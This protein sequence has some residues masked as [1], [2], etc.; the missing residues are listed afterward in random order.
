M[1]FDAIFSGAGPR[2]SR[3]T[4]RELRVRSIFCKMQLSEKTSIYNKCWARLQGW[5]VIWGLAIH[6]RLTIRCQAFR[7]RTTHMRF[8]GITAA[9]LPLEILTVCLHYTGGVSFSRPTQTCLMKQ[10][11]FYLTESSCPHRAC[12]CC[13][14]QKQASHFWL[15][16]ETTTVWQI[17]VSCGLLVNYANINSM[18]LFENTKRLTHIL[19]HGF[20]FDV[21]RQKGSWD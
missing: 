13:F 17:L 7:F 8:I 14:W 15:A 19:V 10:L 21:I 20:T 2:Q 9:D 1:A 5:A 6:N 18:N 12:I 3:H 11:H 16:T 4:T